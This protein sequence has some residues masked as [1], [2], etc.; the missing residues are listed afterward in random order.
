MPSVWASPY[1]KMV[2]YDKAKCLFPAYIIRKHSFLLCL[3]YPIVLLV[4]GIGCIYELTYIRGKQLDI[5]PSEYNT[6]VI[7]CNGSTIAK[8]YICRITKYPVHTRSLYHLM[9]SCSL[10]PDG[11]VLSYAL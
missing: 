8:F 3:G 9:F 1:A 2:K 6:D 11:Y 7:E 10:Y 4:A 5:Q